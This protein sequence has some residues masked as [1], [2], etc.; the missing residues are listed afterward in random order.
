VGLA[1]ITNLHS[2]DHTRVQSLVLQRFKQIVHTKK[3][4]GVFKK[5]RL[6]MAI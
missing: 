5:P 2:R 1:T 4:L 6:S 3:L